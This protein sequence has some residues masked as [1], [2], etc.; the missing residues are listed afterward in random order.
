VLFAALALGAAEF[1]R[2]ADFEDFVSAAIVGATRGV[3][4]GEAV[5][6]GCGV[7]AGAVAT[8]VAA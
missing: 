7:E 3:G 8:G 1:L 2:A 5:N 6:V 4:L